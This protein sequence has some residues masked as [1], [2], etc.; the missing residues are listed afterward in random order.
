MSHVLVSALW[1]DH[2]RQSPAQRPEQ[3]AG[4]AVGDN[5]VDV[6]QD[7]RLGDEAFHVDPSGRLAEQARFAFRSDGDQDVGVELGQPGQRRPEGIHRAEG[8]GPSVR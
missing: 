7:H 6:W 5:G 8:D 1:Q 3:R 2:L 4:A